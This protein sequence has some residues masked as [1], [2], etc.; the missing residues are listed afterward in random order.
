MRVTDAEEA[1]APGDPWSDSEA[2]ATVSSYLS[3]LRAELSGIDYSKAE[4]RRT[5]LA[6]L[7]PGRTA[8]SVEF[9]HSNVSAVMLELGLPYI[10]GYKPRGNYQEA[11][12]TEIRRRLY[13]GG[14]LATLNETDTQPM[15]RT[16]SLVSE[17]RP[18]VAGRRRRSGRIIDYEVLQAENRRLG[19]VGE[20]LVFDYERARLVNAGQ[21]DLVAAVRWVAREDG[22]GLGYD[23]LS[24]E[25][26][27]RPKHVEV[28]TTRLGA[29]TPFYLTSAE[30]AFAV[31]HPHTFVVYRVYNVDTQPRFFIIT[32]DLTANLRLEPV[33][34]R[35]TLK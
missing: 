5:L 25:V 11:L 33:T 8:A 2:A 30:L 26:D 28:K 21:A 7:R 1:P 12:A 22:D 13:S 14:L 18:P 16:R 6:Q 19:A 17:A 20:Q 31:G 23:V 32:G 29:E 15:N 4:H 3:M 10:K 35:A 34:Y 24:F 27:G 9:K